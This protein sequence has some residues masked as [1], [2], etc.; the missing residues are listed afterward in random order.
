[1]SDAEAIKNLLYA[2]I[3]NIDTLGLP[4]APLIVSSPSIDGHSF[5]MVIWPM[6]SPDGVYKT[7]TIPMP[8]GGAP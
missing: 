2:T 3:R 4:K 1:M 5:F 8:E 6:T 7:R